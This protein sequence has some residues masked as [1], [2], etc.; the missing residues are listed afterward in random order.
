EPKVTSFLLPILVSSLNQRPHHSPLTTHYSPLTTHHSPLT[1][2]YLI[3]HLPVLAIHQ[4]DADLFEIIADLVGQC[5]V[6]V[7]PGLFAQRY[8]YLYYAV[9]DLF[10]L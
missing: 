8:Q 7:L 4:L 2:H 9:E 5:V 3:R 1:T 6:S 10:I